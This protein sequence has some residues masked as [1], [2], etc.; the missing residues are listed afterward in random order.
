MDAEANGNLWSFAPS[1]EQVAL[2]SIA[3][4]VRFAGQVVDARR[5][6]LAARKAGVDGALLVARRPSGQL[7][8]S[9]VLAVH[10]H[11]PFA[12][13]VVAAY[14]LENV[15]AGMASVASFAWCPLV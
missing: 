5:A 8:F 11:L 4:V 1:P 10:G 14:S 6:W 2:V 12:C 13:K 3:D 9:L 15:S 7:R